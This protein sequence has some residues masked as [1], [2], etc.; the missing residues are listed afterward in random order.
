M[1]YVSQIGRLA[2]HPGAIPAM[3]RGLRRNIAN[4]IGTLLGRYRYP[5]RL[6]FIAGLPKSGTTWLQNQLARVPGYN[7]RRVR[8]PEGA[9]NTRDVSH[10]IF[11]SLPRHGYSIV[12]LHTRW[13][14]QNLQIIRAHAPRFVVMIRDLRDMCVSRYF[15]ALQDPGNHHHA[16]YASLSRE[17]GLDHCIE[18]VGRNYVPWV[19]NW[20][21]AAAADR[22]AICLV[23]YEDLNRD[24][25]GTFRRVLEFYG[26][27]PDARLLERMA[28][29]KMS[30]SRNLGK[31]LARN[32]WLIRSTEREG[33]IGGW[34]RQFTAAQK[35]RLRA[36]AGRVLIATGYERDL[37]WLDA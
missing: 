27:E 30:G 24:T 29:S 15:H 9:V 16:L 12:K 34:R 36:L 8:D 28:G 7:I 22:E 20:Q 31:Q 25:E 23:R 26:I 21:H 11:E 3:L 6:I 37:S 17:E 1:G 10:T 2:R 13:S 19:E 35:E 4:D 14:E 32:N 5:H 18:I 33:E